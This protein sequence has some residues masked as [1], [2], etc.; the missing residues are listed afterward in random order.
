MKVSLSKRLMIVAAA[1]ASCSSVVALAAVAAAEER[2][3]TIDWSIE[4]GG[5]Q[6]DGSRVQLTIES[7]WSAHSQSTWSNDRS[8]AELRGLTA[9][10]VTG[11]SAPV[12]FALVGDAGRLDCAGNA[13]RLS[14]SGTC[15]FTGDPA[16]AAYLQAHGIGAP[17]RQQA[18]R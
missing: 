1:V 16:F 8:I 7:R 15:G 3:G 4:R 11:P 5:S 17:S 6:A 18:S 12:R 9:A 14:G 13:G 2:V 10:Q